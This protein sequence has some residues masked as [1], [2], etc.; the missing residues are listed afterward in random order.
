MKL[1]SKFKHFRW[2]CLQNVNRLVSA[3]VGQGRAG[4]HRQF[5]KHRTVENNMQGN[6]HVNYPWSYAGKSTCKSS[7]IL[8]LSI[9][10]VYPM[11]Y[12]LGIAVL[13][14]VVV[15]FPVLWTFIPDSKV[16]G[17]NMGPIWGQQDPGGPHVGPRNFAIWDVI[18]ISGLLHQHGKLLLFIPSSSEVVKGYW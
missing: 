7:M 10:E 17:A 11:K 18:H 5:I 4:H 6:L 1:D 14:S 8:E 16:S 13:C 2:K 15:V 3:L 12:I 9:S